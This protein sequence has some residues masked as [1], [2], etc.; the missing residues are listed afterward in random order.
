MSVGNPATALQL[1][2]FEV[3][4]WISFLIN[5]LTS[6]AWGAEIRGRRLAVVGGNI[7][8]RAGWMWDALGS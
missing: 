3:S 6:E 2:A 7:I 4:V 5:W 1:P 8:K